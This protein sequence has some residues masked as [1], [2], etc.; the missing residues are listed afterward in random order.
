[1]NG[2]VHVFDRFAWLYD[3][4][5]PSAGRSKLVAGLDRAERDVRRV[6]DVAGGSGRGALA[7]DAPERLVVDAASGM[8]RRADANGLEAVQGDATGLP[9]CGESVDAVLI[10]DALHH[11]S[12]RDGSVT[13]AARI[14]RPGGVLVVADFDPTTVRG[15]AIVVGERAF[16]F[17]SRFESPDALATRMERAG[18]DADV[19]E[20]GFS[21]VVAGVA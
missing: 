18:L 4:L 7:V 14:L 1:M 16:G 2:D 21:F 15:R 13:E 9:L 19:A 8:L 20:S 11:I 12:D 10:V 3:L 17:D 5:V 6:V